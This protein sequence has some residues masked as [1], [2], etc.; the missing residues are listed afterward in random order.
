MNTNTNFKQT[1]SPSELSNIKGGYIYTCEEKKRH[2]AI[3]CRT[4]AGKKIGDFKIALNEVEQ[5][6]RHFNGNKNFKLSAVLQN[7]Q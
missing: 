6:M 4:D 7:E 1:L 5:F 2:M 3:I